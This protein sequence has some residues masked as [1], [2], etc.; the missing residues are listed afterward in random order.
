HPRRPVP[1]VRGIPMARKVQN[2]TIDSR[3]A[4]DRLPARPKPYYVALIPGELHLGYRRRRKG[5]GSQGNWLTRQY[6]GMDA[7]GVGRYREED[8]G[9]ADDHLD[10]NGKKIF[11]YAQAYD[12]AMGRRRNDNEQAGGPLTVK[13]ALEK[14]FEYLE[15]EGRPPGDARGRAAKHILPTL[16]S[17]L[18]DKLDTDRLR[19]WLAGVA[20]APAN[21]DYETIRRRRSTAN[22]TLTIFR[23][24]LNLA[25]NE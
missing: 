12:I 8:I 9:L 1:N 25:F 24:A 19:K 4:R 3:T 7:G 18:V 21:A 5:R 13:T 16:G 23:A 6:L 14:Y 10:A 11:S 20:A 2:A 22:R 15:H 17:E